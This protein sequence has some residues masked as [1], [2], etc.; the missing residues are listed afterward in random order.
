MLP[1][2][3]FAKSMGVNI[4]V[5][6]ILIYTFVSIL[7]G[8]VTAFCGPLGFIGVAV[9]HIARWIFNSSNHFILI[10]ASILLGSIFMICSDL[11]TIIVPQQGILPIN[12]ITAIMGAPFIIWIVV[13]NKRTIV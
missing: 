6:R 5:N 13:R 2:E 7:T 8:A 9:P 12:A 10:P 3:S 11:L 4:K 1:G